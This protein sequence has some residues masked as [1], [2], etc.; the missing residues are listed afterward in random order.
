MKKSQ[1]LRLRQVNEQLRR[2]ADKNYRRILNVALDEMFFNENVPSVFRDTPSSVEDVVRLMTAVEQNCHTAYDNPTTY[3]KWAQVGALIKKYPFPVAGV[4][5]LAEEKAFEKFKVAEQKCAETNEQLYDELALRVL[6]SDEVHQMRSFIAYVLSGTVSVKDLTGGTRFGPG[7]AVGITGTATSSYRK[8]LSEWTV[9]PAALDYAR[10]LV[11]DHAQLHEVVIDPVQSFLHPEA[12]SE[13]FR[14]RCVLVD[15]NKLTFVPKTTLTRRS[16]A[17]EPLLNNWIQSAID[18][19]MRFG[20]LKVSNDLRDQEP[21]CA[22]AWAGSFDEEDG[23]CTID[24]SSASD[25]IAHGLVKM[26]LPEDWYYLLDRTRSKFFS[27]NGTKYRYE[28]FCS[29]GNAFCF[30]LQTLL[31]LS[32]CHACGCGTPGI[33]YRVY[34]D[35][36]IVRKSKFEAVCDLLGRCGFSLNG[37]KTFSSGF[38]RESCGKDYWQGVDVRPAFFDYQLDSVQSVFKAYNSSLRSLNCEMQLRGVRDVLFHLVPEDFRFVAPENSE[39]TDQAFRIDAAS[40]TFLSSP[41][42]KWS[43]HLHCWSWKE[44]I[45]MPVQL[46]SKYGRHDREV[47]GALLYAALSG[48]TANGYNNLRRTTRTDVRRVAHG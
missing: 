7:A 45:R 39:V 5:R 41:H 38:F 3:F 11:H 42:V 14:R 48:A 8:I 1:W 18:E 31:F 30:P 25:S 22:M 17:I 24:L 43:N 37:K 33:D 29:M 4:E 32:M 46:D 16:I 20:L 15:A 47:S 10:A 21:N 34:G 36:I 2:M 6:T 27:Y 9:T 13:A 26:L 40:D 35:D 19:V 44:F 28:K 12:F 23:F